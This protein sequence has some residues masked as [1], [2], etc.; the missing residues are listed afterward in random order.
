MKLTSAGVILAL[1]LSSSCLAQVDA[2]AVVQITAA[3]YSPN[4]ARAGGNVTII[5]NF[6]V[7]EGKEP[8]WISGATNWPGSFVTNAHFDAFNLDSSAADYTHAAVFQTLA[9]SY[10]PYNPGIINIATGAGSSGDPTLNYDPVGFQTATGPSTLYNSGL[11]TMSPVGSPDGAALNYN[12]A[13]FQTLI[14]SSITYNSGII[15]PPLGDDGPDGAT[16]SYNPAG[17]RTLVGSSITYNPG[18][19]H[20]PV[21]DGSTEG[22]TLNYSTAVLQTPTEPSAWYNSGLITASLGTGG[23]DDAAL[24]YNSAG[25]QTA[26]GSAWY[27]SR[28]IA[29]PLGAGRSDSTASRYNLAGLQAFTSSP[30]SYIPESINTLLNAGSASA[31]GTDATSLTKSMFDL[32]ARGQIITGWTLT[33]R[34][35]VAGS[36]VTSP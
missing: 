27:N 22:A 11:I 29:A 7:C 33:Y 4:V 12:S 35:S 30:V 13:G 16:S 15:H 17:F 18:I 10:S 19:I 32:S 31:S 20:I 24:N 1:A 9:G 26:I 2:G 28:L 23:S 5:Y 14:G 6:Y 21:G 36:G 3:D 25:F 34:D 8:C